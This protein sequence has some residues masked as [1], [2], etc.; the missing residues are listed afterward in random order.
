MEEV[1][2]ELFIP[3]DLKDE[4]IIYDMIKDYEVLVKI[5]EASFSTES[6]WAFLSL[7]AEKKEMEKL[8]EHLREK[9]INVEVRTD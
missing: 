9:G 1:K 8:F 3:G 7:S 2:V 5:I 4:P 6:G